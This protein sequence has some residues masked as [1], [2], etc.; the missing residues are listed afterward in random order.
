[1]LGDRLHE[2][3]LSGDAAHAL[4]RSPMRAAVATLDRA[5]VESSTRRLAVRACVARVLV[6]GDDNASA[7][8]RRTIARMAQSRDGG[9]RALGT[10]ARLVLG[11]GSL[12]KALG[13]SDPR[14]RR[15]AALAAFSDAQ[16]DARTSVLSRATNERDPAIRTAILSGLAFGDE[17]GHV[18]TLELRTRTEMHDADAPLAAMVLAQRSDPKEEG[19]VDAL[20]QSPDPLLRTHVARGLGTSTVPDAAGK[21]AAAYA[22][23]P[24]AAVRYAIVIALTERAEQDRDAPSRQETLRLAARLDPDDAVRL[25]AGRALAGAPPPRAGASNDVAWL[26]ATTA[27][28]GKPPPDLLATFVRADG[29]AVPFVF[30]E[31]GYALI[32]G[33]P[34]GAGR[35]ILA[36]RVPSY[37]AA[38]P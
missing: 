6:R 11:D 10:F 21:L 7:L 19:R 31:D 14:V 26:R 22:Y 2:P 25:L 5:L 18:T 36:P 3:L 13:D 23:E 29:L 1:A 32:P 37:E 33:V 12:E 9:E 28:G 24:D 34:S 8:F 35:L 20:L 4:A 30:D 16:R 17:S 15:Q 38:I 27:D